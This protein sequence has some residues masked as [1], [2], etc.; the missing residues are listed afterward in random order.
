MRQMLTVLLFSNRKGADAK[1]VAKQYS[2][3]DDMCITAED[4]AEGMKEMVESSRWKGGSLM[5]IRKGDLRNELESQ[6]AIVVKD[7][8]MKEWERRC[9]EPVREVFR[10]ERGV[11]VDGANGHACNYFDSGNSLMHFL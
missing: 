6:V 3:T 1:D 4:V 9:F 10:K 11:A 8:G 5:E 7:E 2:Y